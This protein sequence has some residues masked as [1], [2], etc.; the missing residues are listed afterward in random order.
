[1]EEHHITNAV[2]SDAQNHCSAPT[3]AH[4]P[5][6]TEGSEAKGGLESSP[7][8]R[9]GLVTGGPLRDKRVPRTPSLVITNQP[10]S[11]K[12]H[13]VEPIKKGRRHGLSS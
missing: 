13:A 5:S 8:R 3:E 7:Q 10:F 12:Q 9:S 11:K 6:R 1:M 2:S 4:L